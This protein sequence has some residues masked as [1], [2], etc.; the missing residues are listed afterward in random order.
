MSKVHIDGHD[1]V[2]IPKGQTAFIPA[3][4]ES[5]RL[6]SCT[7]FEDSFNLTIRFRIQNKIKK[8]AFHPWKALFFI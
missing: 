4:L 2:E 1:Q 8:R 3:K 6:E 5:F 7:G